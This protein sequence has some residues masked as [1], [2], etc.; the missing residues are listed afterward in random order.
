M[1]TQVA[2]TQIINDENLRNIE[3]LDDAL[4]LLNTPPVSAADEMG[5]GFVRIDS[6]EQLVGVPFLAISWEFRQGDFGRDSEYVEVT[7]IT[8]HKAKMVIS[9]GG[10]GIYEQLRKFT[11]THDGRTTG[12]MCEGGLVSSDYQ[13]CGDCNKAN[14]VRAKDCRH[15]GSDNLGPAETY[16]IAE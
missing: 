15:C 1:A 10:K 14:S 6:K 12:L 4:K 13:V 9:D 2:T 3:S 16:Y 8:Q 5:T 7:L 11:D